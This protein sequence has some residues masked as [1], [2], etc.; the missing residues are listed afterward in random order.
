MEFSWQRVRRDMSGAL[1]ASDC[2]A[3]H[4]LIE[5]YETDDTLVEQGREGAR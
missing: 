5:I 1:R 4:C 3:P 2:K